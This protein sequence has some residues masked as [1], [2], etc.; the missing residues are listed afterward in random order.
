MDKYA[1]KMVPTQIKEIVTLF[2]LSHEANIITF[3]TKLTKHK[4]LLGVRFISL[5][6]CMSTYS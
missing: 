2:E 5:V 3:C 1:P 6:K 4:I